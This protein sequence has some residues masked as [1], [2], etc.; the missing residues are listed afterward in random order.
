MKRS[1]VLFHCLNYADRMNKCVEKR[2]S[3]GI[4]QREIAED[5]GVSPQMVCYVERLR[6]KSFA[7][8]AYYE[9]RFGGDLS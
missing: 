1:N 4:T 7:Y 9:N 2:K 8:L 3:L 5:L 6:K